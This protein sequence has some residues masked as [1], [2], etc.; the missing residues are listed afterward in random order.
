MVVDAFVEEVFQIT[1]R[2]IFALVSVRDTSS[3]AD[4]QKALLAGH[5]ITIADI[6][7]R[8]L[9]QGKVRH[10]I[11]GVQFDTAKAVEDVITLKNSRVLFELL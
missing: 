10:D 5:P 8:A 4:G 1:N 6:E 2:G 3:F 7:P 9:E 11:L